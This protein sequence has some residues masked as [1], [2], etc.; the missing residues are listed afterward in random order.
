MSDTSRSRVLHPTVARQIVR[1]LLDGRAFDAIL[2]KLGDLAYDGI[3]DADVFG[4][5]AY[6]QALDEIR[7]E[8]ATATVIVTWDDEAE[9]GRIEAE[10]GR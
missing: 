3:S 1:D 9:D 8:I 10:R 5:T 6:M 7:E 4:T 2:P